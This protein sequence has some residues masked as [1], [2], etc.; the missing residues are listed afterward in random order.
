MGVLQKMNVLCKYCSRI[1][2]KYYECQEKIRAKNK[3]EEKTQEKAYRSTNSWTRKSIDIRHR[4]QGLCQICAK[5]GIYNNKDL[6]VHH[7]EKLKD[8]YKERDNDYN[9]IT[10]CNE[11][12]RQ[13]EKNEIS[14]ELL[15]EIAKENTLRRER[16]SLV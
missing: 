2:D 15:K 10:L 7:I 8:N 16:N 9:L 5:N 13:A 12:H 14:K 6:E 1:H 4:D 11:H 3:R